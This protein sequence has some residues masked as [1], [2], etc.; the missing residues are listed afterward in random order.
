MQRLQDS[1]G[2]D[3]CTLYIVASDEVVSRVALGLEIP[4]IRLPINRGVVGYVARTGNTLNLRD[5]YNDPR[6]DRS[7]DAENRLWDAQHV[8]RPDP[9]F[10]AADN[11]RCPGV[12]QAV[13]RLYRGR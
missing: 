13:G 2:A 8:D 4:E 12:E 11:G 7:V 1:L 9:G 6:F 10:S 3:R 5:A